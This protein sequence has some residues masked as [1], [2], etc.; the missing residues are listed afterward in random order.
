MGRFEKCLGEG[1][2]I[3]IE[4]ASGKKETLKLKPLGWEDINDLLL[5]GK[6]FSGS[7]KPLENISDTTIERMKKLVLKTMKNSYPEEPEEELK[8]FAAKNF[9]LLIPIIID[10][11]FNIGKT[12]KTEKIKAMLNVRKIPPAKATK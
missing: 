1:E 7:E 10:M 2:E 8:A 4:Y 9:M 5:I 3:E 11:N 6:D 12:E